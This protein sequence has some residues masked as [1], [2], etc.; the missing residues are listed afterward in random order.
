MFIEP[1]IE[2]ELQIRFPQRICRRG[3]QRRG[4]RVA[5]DRAVVGR[6]IAVGGI[7]SSPE[8]KGAG[9][10]ASRLIVPASDQVFGGDKLRGGGGEV[11]AHAHHRRRTGQVGVELG[12]VGNIMAQKNLVIQ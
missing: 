10:V 7:I 4:H 12:K 6:G 8:I 1:R 11:H 9:A 3:G 2:G 5:R